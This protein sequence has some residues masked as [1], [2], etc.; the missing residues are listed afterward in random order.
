MDFFFFYLEYHE[1]FFCINGWKSNS[2]TV[3]FYHLFLYIIFICTQC[4]FRDN[5]FLKIKVR[6]QKYSRKKRWDH[7]HMK[8]FVILSYTLKLFMRKAP[9]LRLYLETLA[10]HS[11]TIII[12]RNT[13]RENTS[14]VVVP[15]KRQNTPWG[16]TSDTATLCAREEEMLAVW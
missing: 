5:T 16:D 7:H 10:K 4:S 14:N 1:L 3:N 11:Q 8:K 15:R 13:S 12:T 2:Q 6:L 9:V